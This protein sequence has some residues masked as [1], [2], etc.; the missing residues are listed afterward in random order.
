[1]NGANFDFSIN[2][3]CRLTSISSYFCTTWI[4]RHKDSSGN[5]GSK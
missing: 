1:M 2:N 4:T 5:K 3:N